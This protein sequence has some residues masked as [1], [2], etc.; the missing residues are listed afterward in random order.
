MKFLCVFLAACI[1][2]LAHGSSACILKTDLQCSNTSV[3]ACDGKDLTGNLPGKSSS[4]TDVTADI[5]SLLDKGYK[6]GGQSVADLDE[7]YSVLCPNIYY[8]FTK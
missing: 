7:N 5:Q 6:L 4:R 8:T 1:P 3:L 2:G